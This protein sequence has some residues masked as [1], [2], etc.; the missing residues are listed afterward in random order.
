MIDHST[1]IRG[2]S[3]SMSITII[4]FSHIAY[5]KTPNSHVTSHVIIKYS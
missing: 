5:V 2:M 1:I 3:I 4:N